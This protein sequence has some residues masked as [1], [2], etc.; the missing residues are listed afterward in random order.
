MWKASDI[1][2]FDPAAKGD[3]AIVTIGQS[4]YFRD[5]SVFIARLKDLMVQKSE[6]VVRA[7]LVSCFRGA[8][9]TWYVR[10]Q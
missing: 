7:N 4:C 9:L 2:F 3:A 10:T 8:A 1:G 6:D 5:V